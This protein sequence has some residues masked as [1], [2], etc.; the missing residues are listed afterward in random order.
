MK[1]GWAKQEDFPQGGFGMTRDVPCNRPA[2]RAVK[3]WV[4][5]IRSAQGGVQGAD[6][7]LCKEH[8][9]KRTDVDDSGTE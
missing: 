1:C 4:R 5:P 7:Y 3:V 9:P 6:L 8:D 2:V